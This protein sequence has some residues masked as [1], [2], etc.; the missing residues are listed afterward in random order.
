[1]SAHYGGYYG[2]DPRKFTPDEE[3][4]TPEEI[5]NWQEHC[6][7]WNEGLRPEPDGHISKYDAEGNLVLHIARNPFGIGTTV[8]EDW[9][10]PFM[11]DEPEDDDDQETDFDDHDVE[12]A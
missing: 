8:F 6:K 12:E 4:C 7:A 3:V 1:M 9:D 2:G 11:E 5:K 10:D